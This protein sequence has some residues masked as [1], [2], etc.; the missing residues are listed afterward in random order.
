M[1]DVQD[2]WKRIEKWMLSNVKVVFDRLPGP[3]SNADINAVESAIGMKFPKDLHQSYLTQNGVEYGEGELPILPTL[4]GGY[5]CTAFCLLGIDRVADEWKVWKELIDGGDFD[6]LES[7]PD[8]GVEP[9]WWSD[10][11]IPVGG[12]GGGDFICVDMKPTSAGTVGQVIHAAHDMDERKILA[13]SW[14]AF[15]DQIADGMEGGKLKY[16]EDEGLI[17][18]S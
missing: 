10:G 12:N 9:I 11:W 1:S 7:E 13:T 2:S 4:P 3:A 17:W 14:K 16:E 18:N 6:G 15:L 5:D 8:D